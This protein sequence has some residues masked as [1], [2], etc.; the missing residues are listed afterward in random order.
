MR[1]FI[2]VIIMKNLKPIKLYLEDTSWKYKCT[3]EIRKIARGIIVDDNNNFYFVH[4]SRDDEFG[5]LEF[6]ETSGGGVEKNESYRSAL[7]REVKEELGIDIEIVCYLGEVIDYYNL[8][9]RKNLNHYFLAKAKS[10]GENH[11]MDDEREQ[12]HLKMIKLSYDGAK[13]EY[14]KVKNSKLGK[15]IYQREMPILEQAMRVLK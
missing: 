5:K 3:R 2:N 11:L 1:F 15:L 4:V 8:I 14:E 12:F 9:N 13:N 6:I 10:F 7:K